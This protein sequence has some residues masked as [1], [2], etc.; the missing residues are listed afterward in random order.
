ML[1]IQLTIWNANGLSKHKNELQAFLRDQNIDIM[2]I[3]E[4]HFT[5]KNYIKFNRYNVYHTM[6]PNGTA[7]GGS[8]IVIKNNIKHHVINEYRTE[9]IQATTVVVEEWSG[10]LTISA[11]YCPPKHATKQDEFEQYLKILGNRFIAGGDFNAKHPQWGSRLISS[12]GRELWEAMKHL[13]LEPMSTGEPTYWP[14][15]RRK[16]R[17]V[18][19]FYI[20]KSVSK[21]YL[22]VKSCLDLSSDHSP[23]LLEFSSKVIES[24]KPCVLCSKKTNWEYYK[25][26]VEK[27]LNMFLPLKTENDITEAVEHFNQ[28]IQ[29]AAW[30]ATPA[31]STM[32]NADESSALVRQKIAE[33]RQIRKQWQITRSPEL[34][35]KLNKAIK[36]LHNLLKSEANDNIQDYL[37]TLGPTQGTDYSLW[38]ATKRLK[39]PQISIPP[40]RLS[41]GV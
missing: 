2:L 21:K 24:E 1:T 30:N 29:Q 5:K 37:Q 13:N 20:T 26:Q 32:R 12:K 16:I 38:K 19:D 25:T 3:S 15:D 33:K 4:T 36:N 18:I 7:H 40:L 17:D 8:A 14:T 23:V 9:K 39:Q 31:N 22:K 35:R 41:D 11:V 10:P 34:K 6:H 27:T 28:C